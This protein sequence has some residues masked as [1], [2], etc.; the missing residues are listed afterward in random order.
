MAWNEQTSKQRVEDND[1]S[2]MELNIVDLTR[3][4]D[5]NNLGTTDVR[6]VRGVHFYVDVPRF[7]KAVEDAGNDKQKQRK[8]VRAA[9]VLR[10]VQGELVAD[11]E[12]GDIQRQTVRL[13][14]VVFKPYDGD[15]ESK[16]AKRTEAAV[17]HAITHNTYVHEVF[18]KVFD[19]VKLDSAVGLA[20]GTSYISNIGKQGRRELISLGSCANLAAKIL[21]NR[22][23]IT[24]TKSMYDDLPDSLRERFK[25]DSVVSGEQTYQATGLRWSKEPE[26]AKEFGVQW[27]AE[28]WK[29]ITEGYRDDLPLDS[30][31]IS[32]AIVKID[33]HSL[34]ETNCKRT[35]AIAV[36]ADLDG[37]TRHVQLAEDDEKLISLIRQFH[38][39][40]AEFE[41]VVGSDYDGLVIQH[42]GDCIFAILHCPT[43]DDKHGKRCRVAVDIA[44]ALQS[45][46]EHV[47]NEH[48]TS[49][50]DIHLSVGLDVGKAFVTRLGKKDQRISICFGPE[51]SN[52]EKLQSSTAGR[53]IR[54]TEEIYNQLTDDDIKDEFEENDGSF[55]ASRL[56]FA[57]LDE[58]AETKAA[59]KGTIG[60]AVESG[61]VAVTTSAPVGSTKWQNSKPW[62]RQ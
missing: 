2:E 48:F 24:I 55:V 51:V 4:M 41:T 58:K 40:R 53:K 27:N 38:A 52:A 49:H 60:A 1:F 32:D 8:I 37:F 19:D 34:T 28:K 62:Y 9:S 21:G 18:N 42:R 20:A 35:E 6:R 5:F 44:I 56:T 26:L 33:I 12:A 17:V 46:M 16:S 45:S 30:I 59:D 22:D 14:G 61:R 47:L 23:T 11:D 3:E 7:H 15:S 36:Y 10:K 57:K 29:K 54:I 39:I 50:K 43:G 13:H 31:D 25:K